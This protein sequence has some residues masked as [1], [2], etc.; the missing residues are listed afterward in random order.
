MKYIL[1][2]TNVY[3]ALIFPLDIWKAIVEESLE[4]ALD[5]VKKNKALIVCFD[6]VLEEISYRVDWISNEINNEFSLIYEEIK[7]LTG[8]FTKENLLYFRKVLE[9]EIFSE[10]ID[11][12]RRNRLYFVEGLILQEYNSNPNLLIIDILLNCTEIFN[13]ITVR[14]IG[15]I[16]NYIRIYQIKRLV[17]PRKKDRKQELSSIKAEVE[18]SISDP[19]D[20]KII[21]KFIYY[22]K[23]KN[24][25]GIFVTHDFNHL[26]KNSIALEAIFPEIL[27]IR[28]AY[29]KCLVDANSS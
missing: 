15:E 18:K 11:L 28:P 21:S 27:I 22:L 26:L 13:E 1:F 6:D 19:S 12:S 5:L 8:N 23:N 7:T 2:D 20:A 17:L 29:V 4:E 10:K 24:E 3:L 9:D 16:A 14:L 25:E